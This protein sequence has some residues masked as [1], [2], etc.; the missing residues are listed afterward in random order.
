MSAGTV[1]LALHGFLGEPNDFELFSDELSKDIEVVPVDYTLIPTLS[2]EVPLSQWGAAFNQWATQ[3]LASKYKDHKKILLGYS[4]GG[5]LALHALKDNEAMWDQAIIVSANPGI[6]EE[7]KPNRKISDRNWALKFL[8]DDFKTVVDNWNAQAVFKGG[9]KEP[10]RLE[11][12][13]SRKILA[14]S[15]ENWG[16]PL[17]QDFRAFLKT[18]K[19]SIL[20]V[21]GVKDAKYVAIANEMAALNPVIEAKI[22]PGASHRVLFDQPKLLAGLL[23]FDKRYRFRKDE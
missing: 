18:V 22:I 15:L 8:S 20:W 1:V 21:A 10:E 6:S 3:F 11:D 7:E 2:S 19:T 13:F 12:Q 23:P 5:R 14:D 16:V 4:Q 9:T 17:Q